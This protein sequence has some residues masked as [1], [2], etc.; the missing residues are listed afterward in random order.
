MVVGHTFVTGINS[1]EEASET[2]VVAGDPI[3]TIVA[4]SN[5][6]RLRYHV[7]GVIASLNNDKMFDI[8]V[9]NFSYAI[10]NKTVEAGDELSFSYEFTPN[11]RLDIRP[12][13]LA[14]TMFYEAQSSIGNAIRGHSTTFYNST[15]V[16]A[17][18]TQSMSNNMFLL[19]FFVGVAAAVG[20]WFVWKNLET[21]TSKETVEMGTS[22]GSKNEWLEEHHN[23]TRTGGGRAKLSNTKN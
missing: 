9:Q 20:A 7:W 2:T 16:T 13:S 10:V 3:K 6:G 8:Y 5:E 21:A 18:G 15:V 1:S 11:A 23:M 14:I 4:F 19:C 22:D 17:P 12:F